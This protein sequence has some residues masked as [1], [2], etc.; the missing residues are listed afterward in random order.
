MPRFFFSL[1]THFALRIACGYVKRHAR[2]TI[3]TILRMPR[4]HTRTLRENMNFFFHLFKKCESNLD[5]QNPM[6][7]SNV[8]SLPMDVTIDS[9]F[10]SLAMDFKIWHIESQR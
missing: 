3:C 6:A 5:S 4:D 10:F 1:R 7:L 8:D 2:L 9:V